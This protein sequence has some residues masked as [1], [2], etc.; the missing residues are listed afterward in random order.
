MYHTDSKIN[1]GNEMVGIMN[2][3]FIIFFRK[4]LLTICKSFVRPHLDYGDIIHV[5]LQNNFLKEKLKKVQYEAETY[6]E[7]C[8][9]SKMKCFANPTK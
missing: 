5:G 8:H 9:M 3:F 7:P 1:N 2:S 4:I 6:S